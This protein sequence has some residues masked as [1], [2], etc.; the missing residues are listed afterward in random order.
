LRDEN[1]KR[2]LL[3]TRPEE[4]AFPPNFQAKRKREKDPRPGDFKGLSAC[5][6]P[7]LGELR[8]E[9]WETRREIGIQSAG[10]RGGENGSGRESGRGR[11]RHEE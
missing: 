2:R 6:R 7:N 9:S 10:L 1:C 4:R 8:G 5:S 11:S 3:K